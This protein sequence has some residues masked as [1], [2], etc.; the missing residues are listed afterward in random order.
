[1]ITVRVRRATNFGIPRTETVILACQ[2]QAR[3]T[4]GPT[5][6][7]IGS[8]AFEAADNFGSGEHAGDGVDRGAHTQ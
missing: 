7:I 1:M 8:G 2:G 3:V 6:E 5:G 4:L